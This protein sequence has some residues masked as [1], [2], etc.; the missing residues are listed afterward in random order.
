MIVSLEDRIKQLEHELSEERNSI[1][2]YR[3]EFNLSRQSELQN[4]LISLNQ[5][6]TLTNESL[7][8]E[9]LKVICFSML[10]N[11]F[12]LIKFVQSQNSFKHLPK[13]YK[14]YLKSQHIRIIRKNY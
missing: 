9:K 4:S 13:N 12:Y 14:D 5:N 1:R 8:A 7:A 10:F 2:K 3:E 11:L 6:L